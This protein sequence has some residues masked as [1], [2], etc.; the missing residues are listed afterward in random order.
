VARRGDRRGASRVIWG[1]GGDLFVYGR[2]ILKWDGEAWI[3]LAQVAGACECG[4]EFS[5][6]LK[7]GEFL[8]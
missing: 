1:G 6:S 4:N 7:F 2:R 8:D 5:R 3:Y